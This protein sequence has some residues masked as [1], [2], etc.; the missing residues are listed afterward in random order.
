M[1]QRSLITCRR[2]FIAR[3]LPTVCALVLLGTFALHAQ[4]LNTYLFTDGTGTPFDMTGATT[5]FG[6]GIDD[7]VS[8]VQP[9]GFTFQLQGTPYTQFSASSNGY[10]GLGPVAATSWLSGSFSSTSFGAGIPVVVAL[11]RDLHTGNDGSVTYRTT[12]SAGNRVLTVE[13]KIRDYPGSG[14]PTTGRM[15][16]RLYEGTNKIELWYGPIATAGGTVGVQVST[17]NYASITPGAPATVS[18]AVS[19]NAVMPPGGINKT[20]SLAP[21]TIILNGNV[22][23]GGTLGMANLDTL[24]VPMTGM[25][26]VPTQFTPFVVFPSSCTGASTVS[27]TISGPSAAD[28]SISPLSTSIAPNGSSTPTIT[29]TAQA[30]GRRPATLTVTGPFGFTRTY[31][32]YARGRPTLDYIGD[33]PQGGTAGMNDGD[34]LLSN[35]AVRRG[36][37]TLLQPFMVRNVNPIVESPSLNVTYTLK[38]TSSGQYQ[39]NTSGVTLAAGQ[40][41]TPTITFHP[42]QLGTIIDTLVVVGSGETRTFPLAAQSRVPAINFVV[43]GQQ[44]DTNLQLFR[45]VFTCEGSTLAVLPVQVTNTGNGSLDILGIDVYQVDT[46]YVQ[47]QPRYRLIPEGEGFRRMP[48]YIITD[49]APVLPLSANRTTYPISVSDGQTRTLYLVFNAQRIDKRFARIFI[50][51]NAENISNINE[52]GAAELGLVRLDLFGRGVGGRF[53]ER[54]ATN[55]T[56]PVIFPETSLDTMSEVPFTLQNSGECDL[57][58]VLNRMEIVAG[59][60][61]EFKI[62]TMPTGNID[63]VTGDLVLAPGASATGL[64][65]FRPSH[66]GSRRASMRIPTNDSMVAVDGITERGSYYLDLYGTG[67]ASLYAQGADLGTALIAGTAADHGHGVVRL[68]N[69]V[70]A[71]IR[72]AGLSIAGT[73][74]ADFTPDSKLPWPSGAVILKAGQQLELAV[75]FAPLAPGT[76]QRTAYVKFALD[77]T[78]SVIAPL[79][80]I[81]GTRTIQVN[82]SALN[83]SVSAGKEA[84]QMV[85]ITNTGTLQLTIGKYEIAGNP[86]FS[87]SPLPRLVLDP[88]QVELLEVTFAPQSAGTSNATLT[89]ESN[90]SNNVQNVAINGVAATKRRRAD[91]PSSATTM[92]DRVDGTRLGAAREAFS[93]SGVTGVAN[94]NGMALFE[95]V[96]NPGRDVVEIAWALPA[97]GP[98]ELAL[99]DG[100]GRLVRVLTSGIAEAGEGHTRVDVAGMANG[101]YHYRLIFGGRTLSRTLSVVR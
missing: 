91:D 92:A 75:E 58:V 67:K 61:D 22:S 9:I 60:V 76:A 12:G 25:L 31:T 70:N 97:R 96:P 43:D 77:G 29:F 41:N 37:T 59:D 53:G 94:E 64:I 23:Q 85:S 88:G 80:G 49:V 40:S 3:L 5:I 16:I 39:L 48:D 45:N 90:A 98:M 83:F 33:I 86:D 4:P 1:A 21:C 17:S 87:L 11:W 51:T 2:I 55:P 100:T 54:G 71:P 84:R 99:Y 34:V 42:T 62:V 78:D 82:P 56:K 27:Y 89:I 66:N 6:V 65:Q 79:T 28:Y 57:R 35:I 26:Q 72:I 44:A 68:R 14:Q 63:V 101:V 93:L 24:L 13:W 50:R 81:A 38:G 18:Y 52:R 73:D 47:G 69:T 30:L 32:L 36:T 46:N 74:A 95:S 10:I 15:Q 19:N 20:Y 8:G 7:A